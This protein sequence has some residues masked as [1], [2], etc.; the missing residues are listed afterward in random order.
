M[1][2]ALS[3]LAILWSRFLITASDWGVLA[4]ISFVIGSALRSGERSAPLR[5]PAM[6]FFHRGKI[7]R[8]VLTQ[9]GMDFGYI[10]P[11]DG[12]PIQTIVDAGANI[13]VFTIFCARQYPDARIISMEIEGGN[14]SILSKN[15][16]QLPNVTAVD[17]A[18][19]S[20]TTTLQLMRSD[21]ADS[22]RVVQG[23]GDVPAMSLADLMSRYGLDR[24]DILKMD[25]E[26]AERTVMQALDDNTLD[27][28]NVIRFE[29]SDAEEPGNSLR[30]FERL[31]GQDFDTYAFGENVYLVR[32]RTH[33]QFR[34][35][36]AGIG[37]L[38]EFGPRPI[39]GAA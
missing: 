34:R 32:R 22:H 37:R 14:F 38:P 39:G 23:S 25:I 20:E 16:A 35:R 8:S 1:I 31:M 2:Y 17:C 29:C 19:W 5:R 4:G 26:G 7:D 33:W 3:R 9:F 11:G 12:P 18:L 36:Y 10:D 6:R 27:R 28:I 21:Q 15:A 24:I 13:G 30:V